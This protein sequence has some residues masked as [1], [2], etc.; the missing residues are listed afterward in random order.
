MKTADLIKELGGQPIN[1]RIVIQADNQH[2]N[3]AKPQVYYG[4]LVL[5]I[6][7]K[8]NPLTCGQLYAFYEKHKLNL[9][10]GM[11]RIIKNRTLRAVN[12]VIESFIETADGDEDILVIRC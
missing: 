7:K 1:R 3:T 9:E 10:Y 11:F 4:D 5:D 12:E 6:D 8:S 2:Y